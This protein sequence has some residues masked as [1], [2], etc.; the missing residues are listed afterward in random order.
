MTAV[1]R[2]SQ[3]NLFQYVYERLRAF[4]GENE[5][6]I[7]KEEHDKA[8]QL[9]RQR[10]QERRA[11]VPASLPAPTTTPSQ[12]W[13]N[14]LRHRAAAIPVANAE[15]DAIIAGRSRAQE[16]ANA[17]RREIMRDDRNDWIGKQNAATAIGEQ[18][19]R[20]ANA[21]GRDA[22]QNQVETYGGLTNVS[23]NAYRSRSGDFKD[24]TLGIREGT[25]SI[26]RPFIEIADRRSAEAQQSTERMVMAALG[27][28]GL[29]IDKYV[30]AAQQL[31]KP[32]ALD[33]LGSLGGLGVSIASLFV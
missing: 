22:G 28:Q 25:A 21:L 2:P 17:A 19:G 11:S 9:A 24:T 13:E 1:A 7:F 30:Q 18:R 12:I 15:T 5:A 16:A 4:G 8:E 3:P 29:N 33:Y 26:A 10:E 31:A 27:Q 14:D 20:I 6:R 32:T 23:N